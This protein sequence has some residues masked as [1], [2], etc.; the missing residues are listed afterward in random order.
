[1]IT[2]TN[3]WG[4]PNS[5]TAEFVGLSSDFEEIQN[6]VYSPYGLQI[7]N[8]STFFCMDTGDFYM[9]SA[10]EGNEKWWKIS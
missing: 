5:D 4:K 2:L 6:G 3:Y 9:Y 8:G 10:A 1:M 7:K